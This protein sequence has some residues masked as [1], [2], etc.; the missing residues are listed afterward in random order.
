MTYLELPYNNYPDP[1]VEIGGLYRPM[2]RARAYNGVWGLCPQ[3]GPIGQNPWSWTLFGVVI[4][5]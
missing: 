2:W 5:L 4:W 1:G 3:R